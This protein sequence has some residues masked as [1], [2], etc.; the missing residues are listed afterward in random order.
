VVELARAELG[1]DVLS[2]AVAVLGLAF[3]PDSDDVR[4]S[5]A[6]DVARRLIAEGAIVTATDPHAIETARRMVPE[7]S[8][9]DDLADALTGA[10]LVL[11]LTE[12]RQ[13]VE[14]DPEAVGAL[15]SSRVIIDAR[16]CLD[17]DRW[18][19]A[20]WR[21]ITLGR[22]LPSAVPQLAAH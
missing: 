1:G 7:L 14:L 10:D 20:G 2:R 17:R 21:V 22:A 16:G 9:T 12:W 19:A 11:L 8:Y 5:P 4:D 3:K 15:V 6:L 18:T 13:F